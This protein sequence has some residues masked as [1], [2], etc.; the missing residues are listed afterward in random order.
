M[1]PEKCFHC[2]YG[3]SCTI[4]DCSGI[5][6]LDYIL[7]FLHSIFLIFSVGIVVMWGVIIAMILL[8]SAATAAFRRKTDK[9]APSAIAVHWTL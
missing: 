2:Y 5:A 6:Q 1:T 9:L 7:C 4:T 3:L 8:R